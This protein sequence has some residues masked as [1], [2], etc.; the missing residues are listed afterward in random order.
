VAPK[1]HTQHQLP[2]GNRDCT[3]R[4][5]HS[6]LSFSTF[7]TLNINEEKSKEVDILLDVEIVQDKRG[8]KR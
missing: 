5:N 1:P 2:V 7:S 8:L 6:L 4:E 3:V